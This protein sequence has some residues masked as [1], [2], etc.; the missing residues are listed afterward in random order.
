MVIGFKSDAETD[1]DSEMETL[2]DNLA[3]YCYGVNGFDSAKYEYMKEQ[4]LNDYPDD[5]IEIVEDVVQPVE[6]VSSM[7]SGPM[8][9][10]WPMFGHDTRHTGRSQYSTE[11]NH[12]GTQ[13]KFDTEWLTDSSPVIDS[14]GTIYITDWDY[15]YAIYPN[16]TEKWRFHHDTMT[17]SSP[18]MAEDGTIYF[19]GNNAKLYAVNPNGTLKWKFSAN[20]GIS[21]APTIGPDGIIYFNTFDENGRFYA[22]YPNGTEKWRYDADFY[23]YMTPVIA[24]DG[25]IFFNS[26]VSLYRFYNNGT[27][28]WKKK[29]GDPNFTFLGGPSIG[30]DGIIYIPCDPGY[31]YAVYPNNGSIKWKSS[32]GWGSWAAPSIGLDG[33]IYIGYKHMFAFYP[34]GTKKWTF[35]PDGDDYH[36]IDSKTYAI[37]SDGT[38]YI[39]TMRDSQNCFII[40][41]NP[42]GTEKWRE[43]ISN[44]RA[45]SSPII[46]IDGTVYIGA[47]MNDGGALYAFNGNKFE[48]PVIVEPEAGHLYFLDHKLWRTLNGDSRC[49]GKITFK[50]YHPD[51]ENVSHMEFWIGNKKHCTLTN[52]PYEWTW[53]NRTEFS[54]WRLAYSIKVKA[55]N[56]TGM[57]KSDGMRL[58]RFF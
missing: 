4:M 57:T 43:K 52:P 5:E 45:L 6:P 27:L 58:W 48:D 24:D 26:H 17:D 22:V 31:L 9:S 50:V 36:N 21:C 46:G 29:I 47:H 23:C 42:D 51:L 15:L 44:E 34:N 14:N 25:T 32:T 18:A 8:D 20:D 19:G 12:G 30:D 10:P 54:H 41:L 16:G 2:L 55:V 39:G 49:I 53:T 11:N 40:A 7:L 56:H 13:W 33:T 35:K 38:I 37:S 1:V 28:I 3:Y